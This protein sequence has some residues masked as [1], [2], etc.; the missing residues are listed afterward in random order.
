MRTTRSKWSGAVPVY[1]LTVQWSGRTYRA[2]TQPINVPTTSG[3]TITF[4][5]GLVDD[6]DINF[7][8]PDFGFQVSSYST[9]IAVY[10]GGVDF[11]LQAK[12]NNHFDNAFCQLDY[13][14][15][16]DDEIINFEDRIKLVHGYAK[17]PVYAHFDKP[18]SYIEFSIENPVIDTSA[19][20]L[21]VGKTA[22]IASK[23][24]SSTI[25][26][27]LSP[28]S[29]IFI[30]GTTFID[31]AQVHKG[32]NIPFV[33]GAA[34][35]F[36]DDQNTL[37]YFGA[38]PAYVIYATSGGSN[39]IWL[40]IAAHDVDAA[41][42]RVYDDKGNFRV[43][44][45]Q[46]FISRS[47]GVFCF[48]EFTHSS[49]GFQNPITDESSRYY[50]SWFDG[51]GYRSPTTN[52]PIT[53][54]GDLCLYML[55]LGNQEIDY[56]SWYSIKSLI[57]SYKFS[58]YI[59]DLEVAPIQFLENEIVPFLPIS[60]IQSNKGLK[61]V[62]N[63]LARGSALLSI[64][65]I[66][67][68]PEFA[69][70]GAITTTGDTSAIIN[71]YSLEY[72]YDP[73]QNEHKSIMRITG[74]TNDLYENVFSNDLSIESFQRFGN[75]PQIDKSNYIHDAVTASRVCSDMI[76]F[77]AIP[78]QTVQY[79]V[80]PKYGFIDVGDIITLTDSEADF[81][82]ILVQ[83][84]MKRWEDTNWLYTFKVA[85]KGYQE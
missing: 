78:Q 21:S 40:A 83:V 8:L 39:N 50:C 74:A 10:I 9:P 53:T 5:G 24:L 76:T 4:C 82:R 6:P 41:R 25:N 12:R 73:H 71:D 44:N 68:S 49:G 31:V 62:Y 75:R 66:D 43:E 72:V 79:I 70:N 30:A 42:V 84:I 27:L 22:Q 13:V 2:S 26:T 1:L 52:Q 51:G 17:Q 37:Q 35:T 57:D 59:N 15:V 16:K 61:P 7:E 46:K 47:G 11:A 64:A 80:A 20:A 32:K 18:K 36:I 56:D 65:H 3:G 54:A 48:V 81:E 38:S 67:A 33:F 34:G 28:F 63:V 23:E 14:L 85:P 77:N 45:V 19:Y 60:I 55:S 58:G 29:S 69:L